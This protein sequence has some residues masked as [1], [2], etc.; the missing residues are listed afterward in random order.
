MS[1]GGKYSKGQMGE[2]RRYAKTEGVKGTGKK[3]RLKGTDFDAIARKMG[4]KP[5]G[6]GAGK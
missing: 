5:A 2:M 4:L 6:K 1:G 3:G